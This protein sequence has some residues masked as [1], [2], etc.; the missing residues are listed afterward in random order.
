MCSPPGLGLA[1]GAGRAGDARAD[2]STFVRNFGISLL[3]VLLLTPA[4]GGCRGG[5][6]EETQ[7][8][9]SGLAD[10]NH[11][12]STRGDDLQFPSGLHWLGDEHAYGE[13]GVLFVCLEPEIGGTVTVTGPEGVTVSPAKRRVDP[14]GDGILRFELRVE[15]GATGRLQAR[16]VAEAGSSTLPGPEVATGESGWSL[17]EAG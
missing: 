1:D 12:P 5:P 2:R 7:A 16:T 13:P 15:P 14:D 11:G 17:R 8:A 4:L 3:A 9:P 6:S 10:C